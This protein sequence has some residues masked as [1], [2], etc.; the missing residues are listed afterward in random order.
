M[1]DMSN[2]IKLCLY[3]IEILNTNTVICIKFRKLGELIVSIV[4]VL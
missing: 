4:C 2:K 1:H 3:E